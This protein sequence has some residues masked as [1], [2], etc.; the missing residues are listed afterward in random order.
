[1]DSLILT[2]PGANFFASTDAHAVLERDILP[3]YVPGCRWFGGKARDPQRFVVEDILPFSNEETGGRLLLVR[4]EYASG[5]PETYLL[6]VLIGPR[7]GA[8]ELTVIATFSDG[9]ALLDALEDSERR[10]ELLRLIRTG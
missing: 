3:A 10:A 9:M 2:T 6:P 5:E 1:M 8:D 7:Q 4:A